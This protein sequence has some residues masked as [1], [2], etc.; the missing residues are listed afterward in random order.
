MET[1]LPQ[2]PSQL[3]DLCKYCFRLTRGNTPVYNAQMLSIV[4][5]APKVFH[6]EALRQLLA[7]DPETGVFVASTLESPESLLLS[8]VGLVTLD[9]VDQSV[10][11]L[12]E[13]VEQIVW[14]LLN[15]EKVTHNR[16]NPLSRVLP[17]GSFWRRESVMA[18]LG[19][20]CLSH[21][22]KNLQAINC[23]PEDSADVLTDPQRICAFEP[24]NIRLSRR[25]LGSDAAPAFKPEVSTLYS[26]FLHY[27]IDNWVC[28]NRVVPELGDK[29][30][31]IAD[32]D[33]KHRKLLKDVALERDDCWKI[34]PWATS[35]L[36]QV[37]N[38]TEMFAFSVSIGCK[39]LL[40]IS[41]ANMNS[42]A[43]NNLG[44]PLSDH[45]TLPALHVA[46]KEGHNHI[47]QSLLEVCEPLQESV[48]NL[49]TALHYAAEAGHLECVR[50]FLANWERPRDRQ[51]ILA[52]A[53]KDGRT[54]LHLAAKSGH[55]DV[56]RCLMQDYG[57]N[58]SLKDWE[59]KS[60]AEVAMDEG[61]GHLLRT[62]MGEDQLRALRAP[63]TTGYNA[64]FRA[65]RTG[66][67]NRVAALCS[68]IDPHTQDRRGLTAL[69]YA[70]SHG[71]DTVI[72][73]I[74][75]SASFDGEKEIEVHDNHGYTALCNAAAACDEEMVDLIV[76]SSL[77]KQW[78]IP[79]YNHWLPIELAV[80]A[81]YSQQRLE[82]WAES[83]LSNI[84]RTLATSP[85][86]ATV[87][88]EV[89]HSSLRAAAES[90]LAD[91]TAHLLQE[92]KRHSDRLGVVN[93]FAE[94]N[95]YMTRRGMPVSALRSLG[96]VHLDFPV[97]IFLAA[98]QGHHDTLT[99]L[100]PP[101]TRGMTPGELILQAQAHA[102]CPK[103]LSEEE[104]ESGVG[105]WYSIR[106]LR[107]RT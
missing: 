79:T 92:W 68:V 103:Q 83:R 91:V 37:Q 57:A 29:K 24:G 62:L 74:I 106:S 66:N 56:A 25:P 71:C 75:V 42:L 52:N 51:Q 14:S 4:C 84:I 6:Q 104:L 65:A 76:H 20:S 80:F 39:P 55:E 100:M 47:L 87:K 27:A 18:L 30:L 90:G 69:Y 35:Q 15:R 46:C 8:G 28:C 45:E 98:M 38:L 10:S 43:R 58:P 1:V 22:L 40:S 105:G 97:P 44:G 107:P 2:L 67:A 72:R 96:I 17:D 23:H 53:D 16:S 89:F 88:P 21:V 5:T 63:E 85:N 60:P 33:R 7:L 54:A 26:D 13:S 94:A 86:F 81:Y 12:H 3:E 102:N 61:Y 49:R 70:S 32:V 99:L 50:A 36:S 31:L 78:A 95:D 82:H 77:A 73:S 93:A 9:V 101:E 41:L 59:N 34:R 48:H 11:P 64:L 19:L